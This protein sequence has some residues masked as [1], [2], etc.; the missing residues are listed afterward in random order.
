MPPAKQYP[1][2][3]HTYHPSIYPE[4]ASIIESSSQS[5]SQP[6]P[7]FAAAPERFDTPPVDEDGEIVGKGKSQSN[8]DDEEAG[9]A[10]DKVGSTTA[11]RGTKLVHPRERK[12]MT[13]V[14]SRTQ[15]FAQ[16]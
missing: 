9:E 14:L 8:L 10:D 2:P 5:S 11:G 12:K 7:V 3:L 1:A 15:T 16:L 6:R 4:A 13:R